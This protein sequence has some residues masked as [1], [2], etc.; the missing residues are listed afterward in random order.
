[1]LTGIFAINA[2]SA[3]QKRKVH[4]VEKKGIVV[5]Q[6]ENLNYSGAWKKHKKV[7][8][9]TG[10]GYIVWTGRESFK[11]PD[12]GK[13]SVKIKINSPGTYQFQY[14][15]KVGKGSRPTE[16]N[17]T[18]VRFPNA[19]DFWGQSGKKKV[20]PSGSGKKPIVE[21]A[22]KNG[23]F[24]VFITGTTKWTWNTK[25]HDFHGWNLYVKFKK[26][27]VYTMELAGRSTHHLIDRI[28]LSKPGKNATR[29]NLRETKPSRRSSIKVGER[30]ADINMGAALNEAENADKNNQNVDYKRKV[31]KSALTQETTQES[32]PLLV[33][34]NPAT[35]SFT[36]NVS[37]MEH[38]VVSVY[39]ANGKLVEQS[40]PTGNQVEFLLNET[41]K[42]GVYM[43]NAVDANG[44]TFSTKVL[45]R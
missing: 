17:D 12:G 16:H 4:Y 38:A 24:K 45:V 18:W 8:G 7:S 40:K 27:G 5:M 15:S 31:A 6:A 30:L 23:W 11:Q 36:V 3:A 21:G 22:S 41:F 28:V 1:M 20:Y 44:K 34:P 29:L 25:V 9:S 42:A 10:S 14:R 35:S 37:D 19:H 32:S 2:N 26:P 33:Y 43:V 39:N 13:I